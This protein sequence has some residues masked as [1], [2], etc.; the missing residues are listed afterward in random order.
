MIPR[1]IA[2]KPRISKTLHAIDRTALERRLVKES[3]YDFFL[4]F[5]PVVSPEVLVDN[6]H[7]KFIC[8]E[9]QKMAERVFLRKPK[10]YDLVLNVPPGS[11]KSTITSVMFPAW[12]WCRQPSFRS[13]NACYALDLALFLAKQ[14][15]IV[16][17]SEKYQ[18]L[19]PE[20]EIT[21]E[22]EGIMMTSQN[23]Q[24]IAAA[25]GGRVLGLHAHWITCDDLL[26]P[27]DALTEVGLAAARHFQEHTIPHRVVNKAV[28]PIALIMQ[29]LAKEDPTDYML[30]LAQ[31]EGSVPVRHICLPAT[32]EGADDVVRPRGLRSRYIDGL[33]DPL[34]FPRP[35]LLTEKARSPMGYA[36]QFLQIP[37][38][39]EGNQ[40]D[41][42]K[43][44]ILPTA[45]T[46]F[47]KRVIRGWDKAATKNG[48]DYTAGVKMGQALDG[49]FWILDVEHGQWDSTEREARM[50]MVA[51]RDTRKVRIVIEQEGG[52]SGKDSMLATTRNLAGFAVKHRT[53]GRHTGGKVWR[54]DPL[55][56]QVNAGNVRMVKAPWNEGLLEE[57]KYFPNWKHDDRVDA[58]SLAFNE[59]V[60]KVRAG[61]L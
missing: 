23:G 31:K 41:V 61:A 60:G 59:L 43:I 39:E 28:T 51:V 10:E 18:K 48:G 45:P 40:F 35:V 54:A 5:W 37:I 15:R 49:T 52:S 30:K 6:W 2:E 27:K 17:Q 57:L 34:R 11:T 20:V 25:V 42:T 38:P 14:C 46:H 53:M 4:R 21:S 36:G 9:Y 1:M 16:M 13:I 33:L 55:A 47:K 3:F 22:A 12:C 8:D 26:N 24:R 29:R 56:G 50:K 7:I 44:S 58:S 19:F 32:L